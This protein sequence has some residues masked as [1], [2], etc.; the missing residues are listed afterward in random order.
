MDAWGKVIRDVAP[1]L[2]IARSVWADQHPENPYIYPLPYLVDLI[3]DVQSTPGGTGNKAL[4]TRTY[5]LEDTY[6]RAWSNNDPVQVRESFQYIDGEQQFMP[7]PNN[8]ST[9]NA[10]PWSPFSSPQEMFSGRFGDDYSI[11]PGAPPYTAVWFWQF[12]WATGFT[13]PSDFTLLP[14]PG[15][16][17]GALPG[18]TGPVVPLM[19]KSRGT[20][21][22]T[23][24]AMFGYQGVL[25]RSD[26]IGI[27]GATG[28]GTP[29]GCPKQLGSF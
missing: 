4:R 22:P 26:Y 14:V 17:G 7:K 11:S 18:V 1:I 9:P 12:Y 10:V 27:N 20:L 5:L 13:A 23:H 6:G 15:V 16:T 2:F 8:P 28:P 25:L 19:I 21:D 24:C 29:P 3:D